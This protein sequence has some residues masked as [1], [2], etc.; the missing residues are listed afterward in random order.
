MRVWIGITGGMGK[1]WIIQMVGDKELPRVGH[2]AV[3]SILMFL[4]N[5]YHTGHKIYST[6]LLTNQSFVIPLIKHSTPHPSKPAALPHLLLPL[7]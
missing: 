1:Y 7:S 6:I 3:S 4:F 5:C 2:L